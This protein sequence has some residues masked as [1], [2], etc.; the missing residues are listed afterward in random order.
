MWK[1]I[2]IIYRWIVAFNLPASNFSEILESCSFFLYIRG[3]FY[4]LCLRPFALLMNLKLL[5]KKMYIYRERE[6]VQR[7]LWMGND[8][9]AFYLLWM[10]NSGFYQKCNGYR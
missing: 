1:C 10:S 4:V 9:K 3:F 7:H 5:I 8:P 6:F 2:Y